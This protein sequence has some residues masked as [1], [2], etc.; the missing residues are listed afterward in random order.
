MEENNYIKMLNRFLQGGRSAQEERKL[1]E[2]FRTPDKKDELFLLYQDH[3][4]KASDCLDNDIQQRMFEHIGL[5]IKEADQARKIRKLSFRYRVAQVAVACILFCF[6]I[7][8]YFLQGGQQVSSGYLT[9]KA[10]R[11]QKASMELPD[12]TLV[13]LNSDTKMKYS[14]TYNHKDR[15]VKLD[16]EAYFEVAKDLDKPFIVQV[17]DM[18]IEALGTAFNVKAYAIDDHIYATLMEGKV[19][20]I[21]GSDRTLLSPNEHLSYSRN[22][23]KSVKTTLYNTDLV[24][25]W[26]NGRIVFSGETLGEAAVMLE[27]IY[28]IRIIFETDDI[29][30]YTLLGTIKNNSLSNVFEIMSLTVPITYTIT[31]NSVIIRKNSNQIK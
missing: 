24:S 30:T 23:H 31:D 4:E 10:D 22:T 1:F 5:K 18:E 27:R 2:W 29:K 12:G 14:N 15:I 8:F 20:V 7:S 6:G 9:I 26:Q 25:A 28:N 16:G 19:A 17:N 21:T 3:L 13:W 11:G